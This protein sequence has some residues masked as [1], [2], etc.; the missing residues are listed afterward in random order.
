MRL[1]CPFRQTSGYVFGRG[2]CP[3]C[4][5]VFVFPPLGDV[6]TFVSLFGHHRLAGLFLHSDTSLTHFL[7]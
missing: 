2:W 6:D 1:F 4:T 5:I 3:S 7:H